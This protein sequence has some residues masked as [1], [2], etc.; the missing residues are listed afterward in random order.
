MSGKEDSNYFT[1][2]VIYCCIT[3][4]HKLYGVQQHSFVILQILWVRRLG[5]LSWVSHFRVS[6]KAFIQE[7]ARAG[8]SSA[9]WLGKYQFPGSHGCAQFLEGY[10]TE[11]LDSLQATGQ[12]PPS[13]PCLM[14]LSIWQL[15]PSE[16]ARQAVNTESLL[17]RQVLQAHVVSSWDWVTSHHFLYSIGQ[18]Q[19]TALPALEG[20]G[21]YKSVNSRSCEPWGSP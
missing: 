13:V 7:A 10:W 9:A 14:D 17:A 16:P 6:H 19:A 18:E 4:Y 21:L 20:R 3:N 11:V 12:R 1:V 15:T 2:L 8:V 5:Q